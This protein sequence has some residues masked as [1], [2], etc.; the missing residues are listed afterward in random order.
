MSELL[1]QVRALLLQLSK[2]STNEG[3]L[4]L[5][6]FK[7]ENELEHLC[8]WDTWTGPVLWA[9]A[10]TDKFDK[11][12]HSQ[13]DEWYFHGLIRAGAQ[14]ARDDGYLSYGAVSLM[15]PSYVDIRRR[16]AE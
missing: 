12:Y 8:E 5:L 1:E 14:L 16:R 10:M 6:S 2:W 7:K 3:G 11:E 9:C 15:K 13:W 4:L